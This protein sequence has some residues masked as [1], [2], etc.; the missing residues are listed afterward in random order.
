M[1]I[2][3]IGEANP[4]PWFLFLECRGNFSG[5]ERCF[6]FV[7]FALIKSFNDFENRVN[8]LYS[9]HCRELEVVSSLA[10]VRNS[11]SLFQSNICN[12][13]LAWDLP[14]VRIIGASVMAGC[15]LGES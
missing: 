14:A 10:R 6:V 7:V 15:P 5:P 3:V 12:L 4:R 9:G 11:G 1:I 13:F 2:L 8:S